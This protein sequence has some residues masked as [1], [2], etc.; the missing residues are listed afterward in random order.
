ML[1]T[2]TSQTASRGSF[3]PVKTAAKKRMR[4]A[5]TLVEL[6]IVVVIIALLA[7]ITV[8]AVSYAL[9]R[10]RDAAIKVE[11]T[12]LANALQ[13][14]KAEFQ[15]FPPDFA[16]P[17]SALISVEVNQHLARIFPRRNPV[18]DPFPPNVD[19]PAEA[20]VFWLRGFR[21]DPT[22][23]IDADNTGTGDRNPLFQFDESR[24][25]DVDNDGWFE[26]TPQHGKGVPFV[27]FD[28][29]RLATQDTRNHAYENKVYFSSV[30][31]TTN[32]VRPYKRNATTFV[33][34]EGFQVISAG[35]DG[36]FGNYVG[37]STDKYY[38]VGQFYSIPEELDNIT[39]FSQTT[40]GDEVE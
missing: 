28:G 31:D 30:A 24:L 5:F 15:S 29:S 14:Y 13:A 7:A 6:L 26:Y 38:P 32:Q 22:R 25:T 9:N 23:P 8:P 19:T 21:P 17:N 34:P 35:Q 36:H 4:T 10:A 11:L 37:P 33:N 39:N 16:N 20:L 18:M 3:A 40:L 27:Y 12:N 2:R 1:A